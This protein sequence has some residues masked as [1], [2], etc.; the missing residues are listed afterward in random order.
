MNE[1]EWSLLEDKTP[2]AG[3]RVGT[4]WLQ[5]GDRVRLRP[6]RHADVMD[7]AFDG[8]IAT[9]EGIEQDYEGHV[10]LSVVLDD[11]PGRDLGLARQVGHRFFFGPDE[12]EAAPDMPTVETLSSAE[13]PVPRVLIA[14]IGNIFFGDDAFGVEVARR[15]AVRPLPEGV[16]V[17]DFGIRGFDLACA[18]LEGSDVSILVDAC[19]RGDRPGTLNI[20]EPDLVAPDTGPTIASGF[21][22]HGLDPMNVLRLA[23]SMEGKLKRVLIVGCEPESL[24]GEDGRMG[25]SDTVDAAADR[26]VALIESLVTRI[27]NGEDLRQ[28]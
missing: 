3:L 4:A 15:L 11:D 12:V 27:L 18:L 9:I 2:L 23:I 26:A 19:P 13:P 14:G 22:A 10:H 20:L 8:R 16:R 24:G 5:K 6:R 17:F 1:W 25:L 7:L 28:G 21:E